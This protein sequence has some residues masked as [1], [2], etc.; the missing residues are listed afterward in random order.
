MTRI[1]IIHTSDIAKV[2]VQRLL[3][4]QFTGFSYEFLT[5]PSDLS[6]AEIS[7]IVGKGIGKPELPYIEFSPEDGKAGM[8]QAG[9]PETITEGYEHSQA[10]QTGTTL[11]WFVENELKYAFLN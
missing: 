9:L 5:G 1:T 2:A 7:S 11:Q 8:I 4:L 3:D 6:F 10:T